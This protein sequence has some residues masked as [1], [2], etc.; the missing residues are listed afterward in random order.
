[1]TRRVAITTLGKGALAVVVFGATACASDGATFSAVGTAQPATDAPTTAPATPSDT[2]PAGTTTSSS[3]VTTDRPQP[4]AEPVTWHRVSLGF[5]SA[6]VLARNGEAAV[7]D[8]G[9]A[10]SGGDIE[11]GLVAAGLSWDAVGH[12][13]LTHLH[14]D[15]IGSLGDVMGN[16]PDAAGY[17]GAADISG[18]ASPRSLT[19]VGD[20]DSVFGLDIIE[21][22]GH[23]AGHISVLD[24]VGGVLV[25]GDALNGGDGTVL[26]PN[27]QF[28][29]DLDEAH[30]SVRKLAEASFE[31]ALF[32]HGEPVTAG[33]AVQVAALAA[34][35]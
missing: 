16:A 22:P 27:P 17:A 23:T 6:Y 25:A 2:G 35:L 14:N 4:E 5:V 30:R 3:P 1:V 8:T 13:I 29:A 18:I 7:V 15:H 11:A 26:G 31:T 10:R 21:T 34:S 32:G 9:T 19:A 20:G 33:A 24:P 28:T 12:V